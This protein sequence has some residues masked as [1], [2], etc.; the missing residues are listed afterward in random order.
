[1]L[2]VLHGEHFAT[3]APPCVLETSYS[4]TMYFVCTTRLVQFQRI[5]EYSTTVIHSLLVDGCFSL[6][7][8]FNQKYDDD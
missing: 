2:T 1:M 5:P 6:V 4:N 7:S 8:L 3:S